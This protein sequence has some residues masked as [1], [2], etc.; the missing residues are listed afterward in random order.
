MEILLVWDFVI[1]H[2]HHF[3]SYIKKKTASSIV[4]RS[5]KILYDRLI[6]FYLMRGLPVPTDARDFQEGLKQNLLKG[7]ACTLQQNKLP[8]TMRKRQK[9][10]VCAAVTHR[11]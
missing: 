7:M 10:T 3:R 8:S 2:F 1:E 9:P 4:E 11:Y 6:T 5:P